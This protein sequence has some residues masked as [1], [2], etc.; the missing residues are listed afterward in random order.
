MLR[1]HTAGGVL[2]LVHPK[3]AAHQPATFTLL[4][5]PVPDVEAAVDELVA[6]GVTFKRFQGADERGINREGGPLI[7]WSTDPAGNILSVIQD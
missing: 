1:L 5:F 2:I 4:N 7:A 3:G 6:R